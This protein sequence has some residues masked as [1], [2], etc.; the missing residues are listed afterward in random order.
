MVVQGDFEVKLV[1]AT[2]D[3]E[4]PVKTR[5]P[6]HT[7]DGQVYVEVEPGE[8]YL[9]AVRRVGAALK[10]T[11]L[12]TV[13]VDGKCLGW[14]Y[15]VHPI[16]QRSS[17][18]GGWTYSGQLERDEHGNRGDRALRF[19]TPRLVKSDA[20]P[21]N[22]T[23]VDGSAPSTMMG[24]VK[25]KVYDAVK[26][27]KVLTP[28]TSARVPIKMEMTPKELS[29]SSSPKSLSSG[30]DYT[31]TQKDLS[32]TKFVRSGLGSTFLSHTKAPSVPAPNAGETPSGPSGSQRP[33]IVGS[34]VQKTYRRGHKID[35][36]VLKYATTPGLV[37]AGVFNTTPTPQ[38]APE[39]SDKKRA[40]AATLSVKTETRVK[41]EVMT[42]K[43][44]K[45]PRKGVRAWFG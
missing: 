22:T 34:M 33:N 42:E 24:E 13:E 41:K 20:A 7:K 10:K 6:E 37:Q 15:R 28:P 16:D 39:V 21:G 40:A 38:V 31:T 23:L 45:M 2:E 43:S 12:Y 26:F 1:M 17:D 35:T 32:K 8:E 18:G 4:L 27:E 3:D 5:F 9:V 30:R 14:K 25:V 36:I 19:V 44:P 11:L 29:S